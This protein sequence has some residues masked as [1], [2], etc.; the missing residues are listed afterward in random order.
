M[1]V[2]HH[3]SRCRLA[4]Y[5]GPQLGD[6]RD[7]FGLKLVLQRKSFRHP[8]TLE[9]EPGL[10]QLGLYERPDRSHSTRALEAKPVSDRDGPSPGRGRGGMAPGITRDT[11]LDIH[12]P[13]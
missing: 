7:D 4:I 2:Q 10:G 1:L 13:T 5:C 8:D 11:R 9:E 3:V 12:A 6:L